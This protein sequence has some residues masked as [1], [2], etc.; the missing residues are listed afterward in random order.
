[1]CCANRVSNCVPMIMPMPI[2]VFSTPNTADVE[3]RGLHPPKFAI[4]ANSEKCRPDRAR[5]TPKPEVEAVWAAQEENFR[6]LLEPLLKEG[7]G[8]TAQRKK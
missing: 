6:D 5:L 8:Q 7:Q 3:S 1:M 2:R 4:N